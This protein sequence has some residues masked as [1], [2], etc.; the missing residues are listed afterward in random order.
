VPGQVRSLL[1]QV[2]IRP[3]RRLSHCKRDKRHVIQRGEMRFVV[4]NAGPAGGEYGYCLECAQAILDKAKRELGRLE[5]LITSEGRAP[6]GPPME[7]A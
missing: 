5:E 7:P 1:L 3:A 2:D 4:R 6:A